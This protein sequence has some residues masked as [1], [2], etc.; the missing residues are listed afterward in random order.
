MPSVAFIPH[1]PQF[2]APFGH[3]SCSLSNSPTCSL[4][5]NPVPATA[6]AAYMSHLFLFPPT[7]S[8]PSEALAEATNLSLNFAYLIPT[9]F[10]HLTSANHPMLEAIFHIVVA[11]ALLLLAFVSD[12]ISDDEKTIPAA[13]FL[14]AAAFLTN[15][16]YLPYLAIRR[17]QPPPFSKL[18]KTPLL[19]F[20]E[21]RALPVGCVVLLLTSLCWGALARPE[22]GDFGTRFESF[23][24]VVEND[25]L[26]YSFVIDTLVFS[27][28]QAW[29][30]SD[31]ASRRKWADQR[32]RDRLLALSRLPFVGLAAYL[33]VRARDARLQWA[34]EP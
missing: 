14:I 6:Y 9:F 4:R 30:V 31:D 19:N 1:I 23:R 5:V 32:L 26:A 24:A 8:V 33:F 11:W 21:S 12:S 29:M 28:F 34:D 10:P 7:P 17:T 16:F 22:F 3:G 18:K 20:A 13:P 2:A 27:L 15:I 25:I